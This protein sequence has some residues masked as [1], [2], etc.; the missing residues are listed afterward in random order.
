MDYFTTK[1]K[2]TLELT[3]YRTVI[4]VF[5]FISNNIYQYCTEVI[6]FIVFRALNSARYR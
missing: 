4:W 1:T 5:L 2:Q 6:F 3:S